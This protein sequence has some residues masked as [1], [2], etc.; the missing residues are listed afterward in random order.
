LPDLIDKVQSDKLR[1]TQKKLARILKSKT[2]KDA[3]RQL[4]GAN[5]VF[6]GDAQAERERLPVVCILVP[7]YSARIGR[8]WD[9]LEKMIRASREFCE[10]YVEPWI[11]SSVVHWTRNDH[12]SR[13]L[14]TGK[15]F[16]YV[17]FIDDDIEPPI[18][19]LAKL[20]SRKQ[21]VVAAACTVR[22]DPP[23]PNFRTFNPEDM[24]FRDCF[25]WSGDGLI[26]MPRMG[27]GTGMML[28]SHECLK[29]VAE[30]YINCEFEK[31]YYGLT[32]DTLDKLQTGRQKSAKETANFWWFEFLKHPLGNGEYG[33]DISFCFKCGELGIQVHVDTT[34]RPKHIGDYGYSLDDYFAFQSEV[35]GRQQ[36][37]D[38]QSKI[39]ILLPT[40]G[41]PENV[42]RLLESIKTTAHKMPEVVLY[43]DD[44][45]PSYDDF[46]APEFAKII[47][48]PRKTLSDYYNECAKVASGEIL[49][50][51][52]DDIIFRTRWWDA[53]VALAFES[54]PD[55][56][57]FV[58]GDDGH[59]GD[60]FGTHGFLHR[61][62]MET[63]GYL[64]P[65]YFSADWGDT[66]LNEVA[67]KLGRRVYLPFVTEHMHPLF[68]KAEWDKTHKERLARG[69]SDKV[70]QMYKDLEPKRAKDVEKLQL[71]I[72]ANQDAG[73]VTVA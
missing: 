13:L 62:W 16:D 24:S 28:I 17:L 29:K 46:M 65:P 23:K 22:T 18:D 11:S 34:V 54:H 20:L 3:L 12:L 10:P 9:G 19:G 56:F 39:S 57:I 58:H 38:Y 6:A 50:Q 47:R 33:E 5:L 42:K 53:T 44:D 48:G 63:V 7:S 64:V 40:R 37:A 52:G 14:K 15:P 4:T 70:E 51:A 69:K 41:R 26:G 30:Y 60:K 59:F 27:A 45:D 21:A 55:K 43:V 68:G 71:A 72:Q 1:E 49:M 35:L 32:G 61:K 2:G 67:N 8:A 66:W 36:A 25:E 31:K 73:L